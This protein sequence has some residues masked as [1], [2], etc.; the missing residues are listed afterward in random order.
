MAAIDAAAAR[1]NNT[2]AV[3]R[4]SYINPRVPESY[5]DGTLDDAFERARRRDR[6][7]RSESAVVVVGGLNVPRANQSILSQ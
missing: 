4:K 6:F 2:R 7:S 1:L 5:L 3:A